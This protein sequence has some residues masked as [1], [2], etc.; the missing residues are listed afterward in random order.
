MHKSSAELLKQW[1]YILFIDCIYKTNKHGL[2]L[3]N[4][5]GMTT[6]D[7]TF[8]VA[9]GLI[10]DEKQELYGYILANIKQIYIDLRINHTRC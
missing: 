7:S 5:T 8:F 2:S 9:I 3:L 4:I 1:P 10:C 6:S